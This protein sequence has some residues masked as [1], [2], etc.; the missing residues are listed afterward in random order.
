MNDVFGFSETDARG[1]IDLLNPAIRGTPAPPAVR[2]LISVLVKITTAISAASGTTPGS[3]AG[4][5]VQLI[6][7]PGPTYTVASVS[8]P[9]TIAIKSFRSQAIAV[10]SLVVAVRDQIR[11]EWWVY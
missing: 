3:G 8:P 7:T 11:N 5:M 4:E 6:E 9:V 1:L 2:Q 10:D